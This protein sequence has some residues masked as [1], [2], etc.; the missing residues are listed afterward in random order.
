MQY[1]LQCALKGLLQNSVQC[2][3]CSMHCE[4]FSVLCEW[5]I[6][7]CSVYCT[8]YI[9]QCAV[10]LDSLAKVVQINWN[11]LE[12]LQLGPLNV[13]AFNLNI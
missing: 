1:A 7:Q 10:D 5:Y 2:A 6:I 11:L 12:S 9:V 8:V 3:V 4:V 13:F